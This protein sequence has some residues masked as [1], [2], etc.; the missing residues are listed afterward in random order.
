MVGP[1][2]LKVVDMGWVSC[3]GGRVLARVGAR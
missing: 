3:L 2:G 1:V